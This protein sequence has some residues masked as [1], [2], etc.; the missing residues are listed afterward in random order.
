MMLF[1]IFL[2]MILP[3]PAHALNITNPQLVEHLKT[4]FEQY[5]TVRIS[6][7]EISYIALNISTFQNNLN[8][9]AGFF[10][11]QSLATDEL[12]NE[13]LRLVQRTGENEF[14]YSVKGSAEIFGQHTYDLPSAYGI[15][16]K[17]KIFLMPTKSV[18]SDDREIGELARNI[19]RGYANGFQKAARIAI[20]IHANVNY[21]PDLGEEVKDA[22]WVMKNRVGTCDE[23]TTLFIA[24]ARSIGI[25]AKYIS[26]WVYGSTGW[27][28]HAWAEAYLGKWVPIDSTW[29]EAGNLDAAHIKFM[30]TAD[31]YIANQA[32]ALGT[33]LGDIEWVLDNTKFSVKSFREIEPGTYGMFSSAKT[34]GV[35][36]SAIVGL[37]IIPK[38]YGIDEFDLA[39]CKGMD[40]MRIESRKQSAVLEA[41]K[42]TLVFW[43][44]S[45]NPGLDPGSLYTCPLTINSRFFAKKT[46]EVI[47]DPRIKDSMNFSAKLDKYDAQVNEDLIISPVIKKPSRKG[48][49]KL[50][51]VSENSVQEKETNLDDN[52]EASAGFMFRAGS[53][54]GHKVYL[55]TDRG[56]VVSEEYQAYETGEVFIDRIIAPDFV[57][58]NEKKFAEIYIRNNKHSAENARL[59]VRLNGAVMLDET[60]S[61]PQASFRQIN[62]TIPSDKAGT[63][64]FSMRLISDSIEEK[65]KETRVYGVPELELD[66]S[67]DSKEKISAIKITSRNDE[68]KDIEITVGGEKKRISSIK[69]NGSASAAFNIG[70]GAYDSK[71]TYSDIAGNKY[72]ISRKIEFRKNGIRDFINGIYLWFIGILRHV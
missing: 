71:I 1:F 46:I 54:G 43:K 52:G 69:V 63:E 65:I 47:V 29:L 42:E 58:L 37:K 27:E 15:S 8:Q 57:R 32:K 6:Q 44:I 62:L 25:P 61:I 34:V 35:G 48:A 13:M 28:K 55:Y 24:M 12:G 64:T 11:S 9:K 38:E 3:T 39:P 5:G 18:Q 17:E 14:D 59:A 60:F 26:G 70:E 31:N 30:E 33:G 56:D 2:S 20:W 19:T 40:V 16:E 51:F 7:G 68:A 10:E 66:G 49:I 72:E 21:T 4:D 67:Y 23:F 50:G 53:A 36:K 45:A 41:G 22:R